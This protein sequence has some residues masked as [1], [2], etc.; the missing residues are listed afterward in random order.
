MHRHRCGRLGAQAYPLPRRVAL[1]QGLDRADGTFEKLFFG[2]ALA[3]CGQ[4]F[5]FLLRRQLGLR[6][7]VLLEGLEAAQVFDSG[8][9]G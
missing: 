4:A 3:G 1:R 9:A 5:G 2:L 7:K 6:L 8:L